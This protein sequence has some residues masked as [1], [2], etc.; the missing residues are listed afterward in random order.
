MI[1]PA[2]TVDSIKALLMREDTLG[3]HAVGRALVALL[4][5][6][7]ADEQRARETKYHNRMGFAG[8]DAF[9][10]QSMAEFY[11]KN[12]FLTAKQ[13]AYWRKSGKRG[14]RICKYAGQLLIVAKEKIAAAQ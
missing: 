1:K 8:G 7:T 12:H 5:R 9:V 13:L 3:M 14:P 10:G 2:P 4:A 6:Q 11:A